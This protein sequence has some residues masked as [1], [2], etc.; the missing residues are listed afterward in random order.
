MKTMALCE[1]LDQDGL[2]AAIGVSRRDE[3]RSRAKERI[4]S[5]REPG[6]RWEVINLF[7][8]LT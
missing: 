6:H 2:D 7:S 5:V 3:A 4:F 8:V 1:G